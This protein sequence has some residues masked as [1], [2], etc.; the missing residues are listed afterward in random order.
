MGPLHK[1]VHAGNGKSVIATQDESLEGLPLWRQSAVRDKCFGK[2]KVVRAQ[3]LVREA[4]NQM[5]APVNS[6]L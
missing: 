2:A 6:A 3:I 1:L 5:S 4:W